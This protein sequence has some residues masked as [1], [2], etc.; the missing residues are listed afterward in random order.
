MVMEELIET[1]EITVQNR[2]TK[3]TKITLKRNLREWD[4]FIFFPSNTV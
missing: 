2:R 1:K 3:T 4:N